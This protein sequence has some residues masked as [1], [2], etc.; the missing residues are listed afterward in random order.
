[1]E[2]SKKLF[3]QTLEAGGFQRDL[4]FPD[5][6][7]NQFQ[8]RL[9]DKMGTGTFRYYIVEHMFAIE[10]HEMCFKED[11]FIQSPEPRF[12]CIQ[13]YS[14][15]SGEELHPYYQ[16]SPN[17]LRA[18]IGNGS[19]IY[20]ALF[21]KDIP[22]RSVSLSVMPEFYEQY[23]KDKLNGELLHLDHAFQTLTNGFEHPQL[24]LLLKQIQSYTGYGP[25]A[26]L[27]YEGKVLEAL[28]LV[29]DEVYRSSQSRR[30]LHMTAE[31]EA[32]L[33]AAVQYIDNHYAFRVTLEQLSRISFMGT[34][35]LKS[36]FREYVGLS[37]SEYL[38]RKRIDQA[39]H[40]LIAT[41]L[42]IAEIAKAVG[43]KRSDSFSSQFLRITGFRPTE[44][45]GLV[46][47]SS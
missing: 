43:Y 25:S 31:D 10:I 1:M 12:L 20:Q 7:P 47:R 22:I 16:L 18:Y 13:Y 35:K 17:S 14:S 29:L 26:K 23:L 9:T 39:Q 46:N 28:A 34:T 2:I 5:K 38:I 40:L 4:S 33:N 24:V 32:N 6:D 41:D 8:Y 15:V 44:Y 21:H 3:Q 19:R 27:F 36:A 45:R 11:T 37:V 42:S 30:K